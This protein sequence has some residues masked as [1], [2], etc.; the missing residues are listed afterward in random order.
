MVPPENGIR[1]GA[2]TPKLAAAACLSISRRLIEYSLP[3]IEF[4]LPD[5]L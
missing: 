3:V 2:A 5:F 4:F 1:D